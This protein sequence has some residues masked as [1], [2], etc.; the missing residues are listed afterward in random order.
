MAHADNNKTMESVERDDSTLVK[1]FHGKQIQTVDSKGRLLIPAK[2]RDELIRLHV[3]DSVLLTIRPFDETNRIVAIYPPI[4]WNAALSRLGA[5][6][7]TN[8]DLD[9]DVN[10][11]S[12]DTETC[13][14]DSQWRLIIPQEISSCGLI[15]T[16][17]MMTGS[18]DRIDVWDLQT[19][20]KV[21]S[22]LNEQ[23]LARFGKFFHGPQ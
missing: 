11:F 6:G 2:F 23:Q 12:W 9:T 8:L 18:R 5:R 17:V 21:N 3:R 4:G 13:R 20:E 15:S 22:R 14:I 10:K 1:G 7:E 16:K 19:W